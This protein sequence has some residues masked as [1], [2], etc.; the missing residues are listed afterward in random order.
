MIFF[1]VAS[2]LGLH[3]GAVGA[4]LGLLHVAVEELGLGDDAF[5]EADGGGLRGPAVVRRLL[6]LGRPE[7]EQAALGGLGIGSSLGLRSLGFGLDFSAGLRGSFLSHDHLAGEQG[8]DGR[9]GDERF[10]HVNISNWIW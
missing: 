3:L 9:Q 6:A 10:L 4:L 8:G 7:A 5:V 1:Q 2:G